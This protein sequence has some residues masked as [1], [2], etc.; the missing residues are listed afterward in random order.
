MIMINGHFIKSHFSKR[1]L[2]AY[3]KLI[4][5]AFKADLWRYCIIYI[6]GGIYIDI[7]YECLHFKFIEHL[8]Q[9]KT[10]G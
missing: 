9:K 3:D 1:V 10:Y 5:G 6:N 2:Y 4:P 8:E 7:K